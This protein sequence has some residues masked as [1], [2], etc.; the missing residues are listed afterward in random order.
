V[1]QD[2]RLGP[3]V[4]WSPD[5]ARIA[6]RLYNSQAALYVMNRDGSGLRLVADAT[7]ERDETTDQW[8]SSFAWSPDGSRIAYISPDLSPWP[9]DVARN[10]RLYVV[11]VDTGAVRELSEAASG[12]VA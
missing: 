3:A 8:N 7:G 4:R 9:P 11:N 12:S 2:S 6:F 1:G 10:G 5:G